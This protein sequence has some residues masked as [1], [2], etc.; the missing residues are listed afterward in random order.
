MPQDSKDQRP[1]RD[2]E[3]EALAALELARSIPPGPE[4]REALKKAGILRNAADM[5]GISFA[6]RGR[7]PKS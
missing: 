5:Q 1:Q 6:K 3:A 7:P 4:R 2:L